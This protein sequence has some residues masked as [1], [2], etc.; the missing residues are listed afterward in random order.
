MRRATFASIRAHVPRLIAVSLAI[1]LAVAFMSATLILNSSMRATLRSSLGEQ[2]AKADLVLVTGGDSLSPFALDAATEKKIAALP[3]VDA[4]YTPTSAV[5]TVAQANGQYATFTALAPAAF[6]TSEIQS[7]SF[8]ST[9]GEA[10]VDAGTAKQYDLAVGDSITV[11]P[12][13]SFSS[14]GAQHAA[15]PETLRIV[16]V[17]APSNNPAA[18]SEGGFTVTADTVAR[19]TAPTGGGSTV[20]V[21]AAGGNG[22]V[23]VRATDGADLS[24]VAAEITG[25]LDGGR[26]VTTDA[27]VTANVASLTGGTDMLTIVLLVFVGIAMLVCG[28]VIS[29]T[30]AVLVSQRTR[31]LALLRCLGASG[32]QVY[33]SVLVEAAVVSVVASALGVL[34]AIGLM[35]TLLA[36]FSSSLG[37][38]GQ[39]A[40]LAVDGNALIWPVLAGIAVTV[41]AATGP[42]RQATR[43]A[44]LQAMRPLDAFE[45]GV[46]AG[47]GRF[48]AGLVLILAGGAGLVLC[49]V[50]PAV[51]A[52]G[53]IGGGAIVGFLGAFVS[54]AVSVV[55]VI[56]L[57]VFYVPAIIRLFASLLGR[58]FGVS[59]RLAALNSVRNPRRTA[60]T[61]TAL[62][63][64]VGLVATIF[65]AGSV[66]RATLSAQ[67]TDATPIDVTIQDYG[68]MSATGSATSASG[69]YT[70]ASRTLALD[71]DGVSAVSLATAGTLDRAAID[72]SETDGLYTVVGVDPAAL[73]AVMRSDAASGLADG[74]A[75]VNTSKDS[76]TLRLQTADGTA[77]LGF[78]SGAPD[79]TVILTPHDFERLSQSSTPNLLLVKLD[80]GLSA[81]QIMTVRDDLTKAFP[82]A[83]ITGSA[84]IGAVYNQIIDTLLLIVTGLLAVAVVIALIGVSNTLSLSVIERTRENAML[85]ALGLT[86]GQLRGMLATEAMLL[87]GIAALI[88]TAL[89]VVYGV[90]GA[91]SLF[92]AMGGLVYSIPWLSLLAVVVVSAV[93]GLVAS[94]GPSR[95]A[96]LLSPI[97][98][99]ATT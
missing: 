42:A 84:L 21:S 7:G 67:V 11:Q 78:R 45:A 69:G 66:A 55:G 94:V 72:G 62:I 17:T 26:A 59:G 60:A 30:F 50:V 75:L 63:I 25:A 83:A 85:R 81:S 86:R 38:A 31:E 64:G 98:G 68:G 12:E 18:Y 40:V 24:A 29:N 91:M 5:A 23:Q 61:T 6:R 51:L 77:N 33:R 32:R 97:E 73:A 39:L 79:G 87:A 36:V 89:G 56:M 70:E 13:P 80:D 99:L 27:Y 88:G 10:A 43:V 34:A 9:A 44:P 74:T 65:T 1:V 53:G 35:A 58:A 15:K 8:P 14:D 90:L 37:Q 82:D 4:I 28:L 49:S 57:A 96:A 71:V 48:V 41:V 92:N 19:L 47:R 93:A 54:A 3:G 22:V 76:G 2:Y 46:R 16:G 20:E 52:P 95:R